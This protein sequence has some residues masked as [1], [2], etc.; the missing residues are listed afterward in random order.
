MAENE[1]LIARPGHLYM[2][3]TPLGNLADLSERAAAILRTCDIVACEDTRS[4]GLL[5][6]RLG[7]SKELL[8]YHDANEQLRASAIADLLAAG[9]SVALISDAGTPALS[10]PGFRAARECRRRGLP[11]VP[12]PGPCACVALLSASGLPSNGFLFVGFLPP[13][14][15]ARRAFLQ[16]RRDFEYTLALYESCHRIEKLVD[17]IVE[18][19]G[20]QRV[21]C[22]GKEL[23][24]IHETILVG[25]AGEVRER[26]QKIA[27]KGEFAA[28]IA[29]ETF[30]L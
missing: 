27:I 22:L 24:K 19:L 7:T 3:A 28:L 16:K 29:P 11:V 6:Q 20:P 21:V 15:A 25:P 18:E 9:R 26:L 17:E 10:D 4:A 13:K 14:S 30:E 2:V 23:T 5:L 1:S 12:V 8:S